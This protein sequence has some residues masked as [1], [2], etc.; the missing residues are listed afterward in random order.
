MYL[1]QPHCS[2]ARKISSVVLLPTTCLAYTQQDVSTTGCGR[3]ASVMVYPHNQ[4]CLRMKRGPSLSHAGRVFSVIE[5]GVPYLERK[6]KSVVKAPRNATIERVST[7]PRPLPASTRR[8]VLSALNETKQLALRLYRRY[9]WE[10]DRWS[11]RKPFHEEYPSLSC[12]FRRA[13]RAR[14]GTEAGAGAGAGAEDDVHT[15]QQEQEQGQLPARHRSTK[16]SH[17]D[18][19]VALLRLRGDSSSSTAA[20]GKRGRGQLLP[21]HGANVRRRR[22]LLRAVRK[23]ARCCQAAGVRTPPAFAA[24]LAF[25]DFGPVHDS[26]QKAGRMRMVDLWHWLRLLSAPTDLGVGAGCG[27][28]GGIGASISINRNMHEGQR[29]KKGAIGH[30]RNHN[31]NDSRRDSFEDQGRGGYQA[32]DGMVSGRLLDSEETSLLLDAVECRPV[33]GEFGENTASALAASA[34]AAATEAGN[35]FYVSV[36]AFWDLL[37]E[38][39]PGLWDRDLQ[40][41]LE[42]AE[43]RWRSK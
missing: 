22:V 9:G 12:L 10:R 6:E 15:Q 1:E 14:A 36:P 40:A 33:V 19:V 25:F 7:P 24:T 17:E 38:H 37:V 2:G 13:P 30:H 43:V 31:N 26:R 16:V 42:A 41:R 23:V 11:R 18:I 39:V 4:K 32:G 8:R 21:A 20:N 34:L 35:G 27:A 28:A 5:P 3:N 29:R